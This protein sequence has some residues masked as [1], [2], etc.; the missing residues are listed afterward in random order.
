MDARTPSG[1]TA[2]E[3]TERQIAYCRELAMHA[4][5]LARAAAEMALHQGET[6]FPKS[7]DP[8]TL[9]TRFSRVVRDAIAME[10]RLVSGPKPGRTPTRPRRPSHQEFAPPAPPR[11]HPQT[12]VPM[13]APAAITQAEP[14]PPGCQETGRK[15]A[16]LFLLDFLL[17]PIVEPAPAP[18]SE[19]PK[20]TIPHP[21]TQKGPIPQ[22]W[23]PPIIPKSTG[24]P[25]QGT[26]TVVLM[27]P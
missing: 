10:I 12:P 26:G 7:L 13:Q 15:P 20:S 9:F 18:R 16:R 1:E 23:S 2:E 21:P 22:E 8:V 27:V 19:K 17:G 6:T 25:L 11:H 14:A 4:M 5:H 24:P 3:H